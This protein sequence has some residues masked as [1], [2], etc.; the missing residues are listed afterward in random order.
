LAPNR[1][2][3]QDNGRPKQVAVALKYDKAR[4]AAPR[5]VAKGQGEMAEQIRAIAEQH[6]IIVRENAP[7][8]EL[9]AQVELDSPIPVEA[10]VAVA[11]I[12]SYLYR[13]GKKAPAKGTP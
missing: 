12:L 2:D 9:L 11:E 13:A 10:Y 4:D 5:V 7:L 6:G 3:A 1:S 8:A